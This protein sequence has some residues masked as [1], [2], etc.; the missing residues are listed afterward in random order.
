MAKVVFLIPPSHN[1]MNPTLGLAKELAERGEEVIYF[2]SEPLR[3][4]IESLGA[5]FRC[6][7]PI[8]W[9]GT[10]GNMNMDSY[11]LEG[12]MIQAAGF[13]YGNKKIAEFMIELVTA[14]SPD[15]LIHDS[16]CL[17]AK[18]VAKKLGIPAIASV[19]TPVFNSKLKDIDPAGFVKLVL[20][21][22]DPLLPDKII[23][24]IA[25]LEIKFKKTYEIEDFCDIF[26]AR[27]TL[28]IVYTS[29]YFQTYRDSFD[30]TY[31]FVG[32]SIFPRTESL[33]FPYDKLTGEPLVY[34]AMG[35]V[36]DQHADLYQ[37]CI[38]ALREKPVQVVLSLNKVPENSLQRMPDNFIA[39]K[40]VPQLE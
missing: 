40:Y 26:I 29:E 38:E 3:R 13:L 31:K 4:K 9:Y 34:I 22:A 37:K 19:A 28:N 17:W 30:D 35:G 6:Y 15:Y 25:D 24:I 23:D 2:S 16:Y 21:S 11:G 32:A 18:Q 27:E 1:H 39:C 12:L 7:P 20:R 5:Q 33:D 14:E 8:N 36:V 10:N